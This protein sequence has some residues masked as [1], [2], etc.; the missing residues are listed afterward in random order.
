M[1]PGVDPIMAYDALGKDDLEGIHAALSRRGNIRK[2]FSSPKLMAASGKAGDA[3]NSEEEE[4]KS[5]PPVA[6]TS[7]EQ[8]LKYKSGR[9]SEEDSDSSQGF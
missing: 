9:S 5:S 6:R 1:S 7:L 8:K 3:S 4:M 2:T